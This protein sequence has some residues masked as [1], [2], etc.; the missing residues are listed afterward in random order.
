MKQF[1]AFMLATS[2]VLSVAS[3]FSRFGQRAR[4]KAAKKAEASKAEK[5]NVNKSRF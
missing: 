4:E 5:R 2:I 3:R 1:L